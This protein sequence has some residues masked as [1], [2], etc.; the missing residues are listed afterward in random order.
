MVLAL[1]LASLLAMTPDCDKR[2]AI[3][4]AVIRCGRDFGYHMGVS[5]AT[6][7]AQTL[8]DN[9]VA[10]V[11]TVTALDTV[12][13][14]YPGLPETRALLRIER[15]LSGASPLDT[16]SFTSIQRYPP[17]VVGH[18]VLFWLNRQCTW[19]DWACGQMAVAATDTSVLGFLC[20]EDEWP[21]GGESLLKLDE[22]MAVLQRLPV[23]P[24]PEI[25]E[26]ARSLVHVGLRVLPRTRCDFVYAVDSLA[27]VVG[28]PVH[29]P[30]YVRFDQVDS[31]CRPEFGAVR[32]GV[33]I[34]LGGDP[35]PDTLTIHSC[36]HPLVVSHGIVT[37]LG[38]SLAQVRASMR[39]TPRGLEFP[40][41]TLF[42]DGR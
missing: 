32:W 10:G 13:E 41:G 30:R 42:R 21:R 11:G 38:M 14:R 8:R 26:G 36:Q 20:I 33:L 37:G 1:I 35:Q 17:A 19:D 23:T 22:L 5:A 25:W 40:P 12:F 18:R 4:D 7:L 2:P 16:I 6:G 31:E 3:T 28:P 9:D 39:E 34:P 29:V 15:V 24:H 27:V